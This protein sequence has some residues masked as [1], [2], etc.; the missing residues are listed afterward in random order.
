MNLVPRKEQLVNVYLDINPITKKP[1]YVGI[2]VNSRLSQY[3]RNKYHQKIVESIPDKK[4]IRKIIYKNIPI[5]KAWKIEKQ[6]IK[7]C[8]RLVYK[9]GYLANMHEGGPLPMEDIN[10]IHWLE[11]RKIKDIIPDYIN[12]RT[13]KSY[14]E[15]YGERKNEIIKNQIHNR[16][17]SKMKRIKEIGKTKKEKEHYQKWAERRRNKEYTEK[18]LESFKKQS[19]FQ[20]G[21]SMQERLNDPNWIDPRKGKSA[22][23]IYGEDYKGPANKG[24]TYKEL[25]GQDYIDPRAKTFT[26]QIDD[27]EPIFCESEKDFC[28]K[29]NCND[30][31]LRKFKEHGEWK[32]TKQ[33]NSKHIFPNNSIVKFNYI[34]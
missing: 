4:F 32:I 2:G 16:I 33:S 34:K 1:F 3:K 9:N 17:K 29:F 10:S 15:L 6:I 21:K 8:G 11:G 30:V 19:Q 18:E 28:K 31:L 23:E 7:K 25:K 26:I 20:Q 5:E 13:G 22:K 12:P 27:Q 24:K 14:D